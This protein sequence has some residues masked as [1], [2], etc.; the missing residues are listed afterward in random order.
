MQEP[1]MLISCRR[2][3]RESWN[4]QEKYRAKHE[5]AHPEIRSAQIR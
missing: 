5:T 3:V 4:T 1:R 2:I